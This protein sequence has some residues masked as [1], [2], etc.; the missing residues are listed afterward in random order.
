MIYCQKNLNKAIV[1]SNQN[2]FCV[3]IFSD[4]LFAKYGS[5]LCKFMHVKIYS[6][7]LKHTQ[8]KNK[9]NFQI[10]FLFI[11]IKILLT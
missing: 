2:S 7:N 9:L 6:N 8:K 1:F 4:N 11:M 5:R 3:S 10:I